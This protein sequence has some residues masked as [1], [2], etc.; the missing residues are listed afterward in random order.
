M[1]SV[2]GLLALG[3]AVGACDRSKARTPEATAPPRVPTAS[4]EPLASVASAP[5]SD[6]AEMC[7]AG[8]HDPRRWKRIDP[9]AVTLEQ[10][11][12]LN[13][14]SPCS[15][16]VFVRGGAVVAEK[17]RE[18]PPQVPPGISLPAQ[19]VGPPSVVEQGRSGLLVGFDNGEWGGALFWYAANGT[20]K[21]KLLSDNVVELLPTA[22]GFTLFTGLSHMGSDTGKAT[23]VLDS[24]G[25]YQLGRSA[26]LASNPRAV[27]TEQSG[28]VLVVT[29]AGLVRLQ[30]DFRVEKLLREHWEMLYPV[31]LAVAGETAYVGMRGAVA[32]VHLGASGV[33]ET[34]L[35]P[36]DMK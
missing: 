14:R 11:F 28:S 33:T 12:S 21:Q 8:Q 1:R 3:V 23:E 36:V 25:R 10:R 5:P 24:D 9:S 15:W 35:S 34:W 26:D 6:R 20:F 18:T 2:A 30:S 29:M 22:T 17:R 16:A 31:S 13:R 27:V 19:H 32:E 4:A 7:P